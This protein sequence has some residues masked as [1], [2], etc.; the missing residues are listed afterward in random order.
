[1][2][3]TLPPKIEKVDGQQVRH[4]AKQCAISEGCAAR[5]T[6]AAKPGEGGQSAERDAGQKAGGG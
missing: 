2:S 6:V 1:V 4:A 3:A 5:E